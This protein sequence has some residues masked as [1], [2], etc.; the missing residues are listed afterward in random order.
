[1][2]ENYRFCCLIENDGSPFNVAISPTQVIYD[3]QEMIHHERFLQCDPMH[4]T[5]VKV[6]H[7]RTYHA[8]H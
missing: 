3:L 6:R 4:I 7:V 2:T 5:L 8:S 1:M